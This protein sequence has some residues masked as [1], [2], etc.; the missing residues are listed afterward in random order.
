[1]KSFIRIFSGLAIVAFLG[2]ANSQARDL[3]VV[4]WGG[5][6]QDVMERVYFAPFQ[7]ESHEPLIRDSWGGGYGILQ[8]KVQAGIPNWDIVA[9]EAEELLL[10]CQDGILEKLDWDKIGGKD[11]LSNGMASQCGAGSY[12]WSNALSYDADRYKENPPKSWI[13][14][15]DTKKYPGKRSMRKGAKYNL[16]FALIADGVAEDDVYKILSTKEGVNRAFKKLDEI[17]PYVVWWE[18][19]NQPVQLLISGDVVMA[20]AYNARVTAFSREEKRN[21]KVVWKDSI[22]TLDSWAILKG[23]PQ[24]ENAYK[25]ISFMNDYKQQIQMPEFLAYG[26]TNKEAVGKV[27]DRWAVD[28]PTYPANML[29]AIPLNV[30][31]WTDNLESLTSRYNAWLAQ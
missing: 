25:L 26:I 4:G 18:S 30:E 1:M 9:V 2:I 11:Q 29:V 17:K 28:L 3:T 23:S 13:D 19:G 24:I 14:F 12:V 7:K 6:T 22:Y 16:E 20:A 21:L 10:G 8:A 27:D 31:F 5:T 15:W